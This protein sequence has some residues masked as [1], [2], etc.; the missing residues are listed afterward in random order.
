VVVGAKISW[1]PSL[2]FLVAAV[3]IAELPANALALETSPSLHEGVASCSSSTCH[4][5]QYPNTHGVRQNEISTWQDPSLPAGAHSRAWRVLG[6][7]RAKGIAARLGLGSAQTA[8]MC[9]GCHVEPAVERGPRF[10]ESDGVGCEACHGASSAWLASH[11]GLRATHASNVKNG[12]AALEIPKVRAEICL[13]CHFGSDKPDQFVSHRM[14][15][16]GHP[17]IAFEVDW[18]S[19]TQRHY[20]LNADYAARKPIAGD[21]RFWAVGQ[22]LALERALTLYSGKRG[23]QG[24]LFPE[25]YFFDCQ[26]CHRRAV[27]NTGDALLRAVPNPERPI[28]LGTPSFNDSNMIMLVA[29][30][31]SAIPDSS[32]KFDGQ[33]RAF[34]AAMAQGRESAVRAAGRLA[35]TA[36]ELSDSFA[37]HD[38]SRGEVLSILDQLVSSS[39]SARYTDWSE[40]EQVYYG[41]CDLES[42]LQQKG[43]SC[44]ADPALSQ[45]LK[46]LDDPNL[47]NAAEFHNSLLRVA[48]SVR[49]LHQ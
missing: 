6:E 28:P 14:M 5:R 1:L 41:I 37:M 21:V 30:V 32:P 40:G 15:A 24:G 44:E 18:Y 17:P 25:F 4:G 43:Y 2:L 42:Q 10:Q 35:A 36:H 45:M 46:T 9:I 29:A 27:S 11:G 16:A 8:P 47:Y 23:I 7:A 3:G 38:F 19:E 22:S 48:A 33:I 26:T 39:A 12:M 34:H 31:R 20:D 49:G 13:D